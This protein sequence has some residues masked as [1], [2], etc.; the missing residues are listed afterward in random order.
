MID[1]AP[2]IAELIAAASSLKILITSRVLLHLTAER[3]FVVPPL[4]VPDEIAQISLDELSN[5]EAIELFVE[6]ARKAKSS[7]TL[8][9]ENAADV[10]EICARLDGLPLAIELAAARIKILSPRAILP[11]LENRLKL[12]TG[13]AND[14]PAR[15]QTMRGAIEWSY[16]LL[17]EDEKRLF[18]RLAIFANG[19]TFE[20]AEAVCSND[21]L[22]IA[23][24]KSNG[25]ERLKTADQI[26]VLD[27]ITSLADKSLLSAKEQAADEQRFRMLE[28]VREYGLESLEKK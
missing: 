8:T 21:E 10:A 3:E 13:G 12:L 4:A 24:Y 23:D 18:R 14:L 19:F 1:A 9:D 6:R 28:T 15:Q 22:Q 5:Y 27:L 11:K 26:E 7:F 2:Q 17:T 25:N 16:D 20:A